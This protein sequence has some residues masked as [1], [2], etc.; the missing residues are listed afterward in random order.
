VAPA[1]LHARGVGGPGGLALFVAAW[2]AAVAAVELAVALASARMAAL[3]GAR[4]QACVCAV[5]ALLFFG[6]AVQQ[7]ASALPRLLAA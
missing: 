7:A 4:G 1:L 2:F 5:A 3:L 6:L